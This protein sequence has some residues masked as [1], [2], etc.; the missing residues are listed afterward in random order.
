MNYQLQPSTEAELL[1]I[2]A[3]GRFLHSMMGAPGLRE[4]C[5]VRHQEAPE[6][7]E[8]LLGGKP[9]GWDQLVSTHL[10]FPRRAR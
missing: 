10:I 7:S 1:R 6:S 2:Y 3:L 8:I 4:G 5:M 9:C